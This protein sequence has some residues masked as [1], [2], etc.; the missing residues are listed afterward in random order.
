MLND[1][2]LCQSRTVA[3]LKMRK[4]FF[5][6]LFCIQR[7]LKKVNKEKQNDKLYLSSFDCS[8]KALITLTEY[9]SIR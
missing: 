4:S 1:N 5:F 2:N 9:Q 3:E 8:P 6:F 7:T